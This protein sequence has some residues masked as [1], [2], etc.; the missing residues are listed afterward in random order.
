TTGNGLLRVTFASTPG[1]GGARPHASIDRFGA[2]D[3][4]PDVSV[5]VTPVFGDVFFTPGGG[6]VKNHFVA[7][8]DAKSRRFVPDATLTAMP[9]D[10]FQNGFGLAEGLNGRVLA[11]FGRGTA[12]LTKAADGSWTIDTDTFSRFGATTMGF[13][14]VEPN[15]VM[16]FGWQGQLVRFDV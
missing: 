15:G 6:T 9:I 10:R 7:R 14:F 8:F 1:T 2:A 12:E 5:A 16:W 11:N 3:G 4:L 13:P